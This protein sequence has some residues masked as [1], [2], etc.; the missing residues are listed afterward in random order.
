MCIYM[1]VCVY[2]YIYIYIYEHT[3]IYVA[4]NLT[5]K[6]YTKNHKH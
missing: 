6:Y 2:I 5:E 1:C 3:Y 4:Q